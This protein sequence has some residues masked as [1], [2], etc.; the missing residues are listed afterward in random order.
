MSCESQ[1]LEFTNELIMS[2]A[3]K[4]TDVI[5][6]DFSKAFDKV[7]HNRLLLK[8]HHYGIRDDALA[9][10]K[11]F[12]SNRQQCVVVGGKQSDCVPVLSGVP[13]GSVIGPA[14]FLVY[15]NDLPDNIKSNVRLFADDTL[16]YLTI[17]NTNHCR[18][19]QS[20]LNELENWERRWKMDFNTSKCEVLRIS[21]LKSNTLFT[22]HLHGRPLKEKQQVKYLGV[23]ITSDL[24]W[25]AHIDATTAKANRSLG[26]LKR[27]LKVKSPLLR[28]KAYVGL[29]RPQ[30]EYCASVWDPRPGVENNGAYKVEMVQRRAARWTLRRYHNT[31]SV[32]NMLDELGWRS[33]EQRRA[34]LRLT[35]LYKITRGLT[36]VNRANYLRPVKRAT[37]RTHSESF[38]PLS[39]ST[40]YQR[41]SFFPRSIT[42]WNNLPQSFLNNCSLE[43]FKNRLATFQHKPVA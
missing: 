26:F 30:L 25:N 42:Q 5:L 13:Q 29:V 4:Q 41:L 35:M 11:D 24:K 9:W 34:D 6:L 15:I 31:S 19:L 3:K 33:L 1:L 16:M 2:T 39:T 8:L 20:D 40:S 32:T 18:Q 37:R 23:H 28:T 7:P 10:I 38:I 17:T 12:L 22:Y 43:E 14:L 27:N 36:L 21:R